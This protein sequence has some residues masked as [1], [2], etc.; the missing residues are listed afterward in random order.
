MLS[1]N[2]KYSK[3][4]ATT[5]IQTTEITR[6]IANLAAARNEVR[7][8][9]IPTGNIFTVGDKLNIFFNSQNPQRTP[10]ATLCVRGGGR[11]AGAV[12]DLLTCLPLSCLCHCLSSRKAPTSDRSEDEVRTSRATSLLTYSPARPGNFKTA[13]SVG[14][15]SEAT[16]LSSHDRVC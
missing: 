12:S 4:S 5:K 1:H 8:G 9:Q 7:M 6:R 2:R 13:P 10:T 3:D 15:V 14:C 11:V 16:Q